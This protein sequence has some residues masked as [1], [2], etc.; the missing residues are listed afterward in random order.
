MMSGKDLFFYVI[1][2]ALIFL[3]KENWELVNLWFQRILEK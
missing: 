2:F 3:F 1:G